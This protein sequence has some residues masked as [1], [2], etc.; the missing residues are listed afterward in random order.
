MWEIVA[1][2][3]GT[4][5]VVIGAIASL[6]SFCYKTNTQASKDY[7]DLEHSFDKKLDRLESEIR[8]KLKDD[9]TGL[10]EEIEKLSDKIDEMGTKFI[11]TTTFTT[12]NES[13]N[14]LL[15]M[16]NDKTTRLEVVI[17]SLA[18]DIND[19]IRNY[20]QDDKK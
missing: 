1:S 3:L 13:L 14:K 6:L 2:I 19:F 5:V 12:F 4:G 8:A 18:N 15:Q 17:D 10:K 9:S 16:Y 7:R 20:K 11:T